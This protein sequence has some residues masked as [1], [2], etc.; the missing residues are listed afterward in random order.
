MICLLCAIVFPMFILMI[1]V[2]LSRS[3]YPRCYSWWFCLDRRSG[4][5]GSQ[6]FLSLLSVCFRPWPSYLLFFYIENSILIQAHS[7]WGGGGGAAELFFKYTY[8]K[9]NWDGVPPP[10]VLGECKNCSSFPRFYNLC[11]FAIT[12]SSCI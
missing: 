12:C 7:I 4:W 2:A 8:K 6:F 10:N 11:T 5:I 1:Y 3:S 9:V